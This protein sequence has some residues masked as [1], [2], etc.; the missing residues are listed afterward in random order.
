[1]AQNLPCSP[2]PCRSRPPIRQ[3]G[4]FAGG[5]VNKRFPMACPNARPTG[6]RFAPGPYTP[7]R[8]FYPLNRCACIKEGHSWLLP[9]V[10][11]LLLFI[12]C[13]CC[14]SLRKCLSIATVAAIPMPEITI[15]AS[16]RS[17]FV[18]SPVSGS[19]FAG[20]FGFVA[21]GFLGVLGRSGSS[22]VSEAS[23]SSGA[24]A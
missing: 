15:S 4:G 13:L 2:P 3:Y 23:G 1:M 24:G 12:Y 14:F 20:L 5:K 21:S 6:W 11:F 18:P 7:Q 22:S 19:G 8:L 17:T 16:H 9:A 10:P